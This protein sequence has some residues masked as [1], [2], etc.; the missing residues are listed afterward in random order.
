MDNRNS[1]YEADADNIRYL[2]FEY[3]NVDKTLPHYH[4][5]MELIF[6]DK[7]EFSIRVD[8]E[9]IVLH[10]GDIGVIDSYDVHSYDSGEN[11]GAY[12]VVISRQF[13]SDFRNK[14]DNNTFP[15]I[16]HKTGGSEKIF[17][18]VKSAFDIDVKRNNMLLTG[19]TSY[20]LG[21][22]TEYYKCT[23]IRHKKDEHCVQILAYIND[24]YT[25][26]IT[27]VSIAKHFRYN[28]NYFSGLFNKY[29][30]MSLYDY[31][32]SLRVFKARQMNDG[33]LKIT[34]IAALCGFDSLTAYYRAMKKFGD[35]FDGSPV[36]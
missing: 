21:L 10:S 12:I 6:C 15:K 18:F 16:L 32:N 29:T 28:P 19:F 31:V 9:D 7:G 14:Y 25:E 22:L 11:S 8:G 1:I 26:K 34:E 4:D 17:D 33:K 2:F 20:L 23:R 36:D 5:S 27:L 35:K 24:H 30:G 13:L 3:H